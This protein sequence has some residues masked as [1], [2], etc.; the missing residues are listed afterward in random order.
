MRVR[1][2]LLVTEERALADARAA[3]ARIMRDGSKGPLD[4]IPIGYKDIYNTA[5]IL[6][7]GN[8]RLLAD[9]VPV[10][11][12]TAV[13]RLVEAGTMMLGKLANSAHHGD[14]LIGRLPP[15]H[16]WSISIAQCAVGTSPSRPS[17][18][19]MALRPRLNNH[20]QHH[21]QYDQPHRSRDV[22]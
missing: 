4:G 5:G 7:T 3:E 9:N 10:S 1:S 11:D 22:E 16:T 13:A 18:I 14:S 17:P 20:Q 6:T 19:R 8:S 12:A 2:F 21:D 15:P